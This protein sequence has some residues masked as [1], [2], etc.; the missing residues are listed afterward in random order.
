MSNKRQ[1]TGNAILGAP[2]TGKST[3][4]ANLIK[5][6]K[7]PNALIYKAQLNIDDEAFKAFPVC[8]FYKYKGGKVKI[9]NMDIPYKE[10]LRQVYENFRNGSLLIDDAGLFEKRLLSDEMLNILQMRRHM[11]VDVYMI[12]HG[13][14]FFPIEQAAFLNNMV[15]FHTTD[16]PQYKGSKLPAFN[17]MM[18]AK[19]RIAEIHKTNPH[20]CEVIKLG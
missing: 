18:R 15:L 5:L 4:S 8:D 17:E 11:G 19:Q 9:S 20:Y 3:Y 2:G 13:F 16:N 1:R 14:T 10:F 6:S 12:Y 7:D